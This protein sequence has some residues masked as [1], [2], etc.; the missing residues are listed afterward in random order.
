MYT[1]IPGP[2]ASGHEEP[3]DQGPAAPGP[4]SIY[5]Y[6]YLS[7]DIYIYIYVYRE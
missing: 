6:I 1:Y 7:L 5:I 2:P 3:P 4:L